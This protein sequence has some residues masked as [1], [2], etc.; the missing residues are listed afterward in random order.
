MSFIAEKTNAMR[1][2]L[3]ISAVVTACLIGTLLLVRD[4]RR[5]P[6]PEPRPYQGEA[7]NPNGP[8][9]SN[10][11]LARLVREPQNTW[12]NLAFVAGG[13]LLLGTARSRHGRMI[14]APLVGVGIG[15]F[16]YHA[17]AS[18][19]LREL[20]VAAMYWLFAMAAVE[21]AGALSADFRRRLDGWAALSLVLT[22]AGAV[23]LTLARNVVAFGFKPLSL[24]VT[25]AVTAAVLIFTLVMITVR[26]SRGPGSFVELTVLLLV[27]AAAVCCQLADRPGGI[28]YRPGAFVQAHALWH[29]LAA[30]AFVWAMR[31]LDR[32]QQRPPAPA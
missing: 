5:W 18:A 27:F 22:L 9:H 32:P 14:G 19:A 20:D 31:T 6:S 3:S 1:R 30:I 24:T 29:L 21:C 25:T 8:G 26:R 11:A 15:S 2:A 10:A 28:L 17:S 7:A 12:S 23:G 16:L 13:A 4:A